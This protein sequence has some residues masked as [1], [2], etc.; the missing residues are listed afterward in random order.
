METRDE[1]L[2]ASIAAYNE[3]DCRATLA[4]RDWLVAHRPDD[5]PW[6]E[7]V[8][9]EA[10]DDADAGER[11]ELRAALVE[12]ADP[13]SARWL[14]GELL[15]YHRREARPGWWW[16]FERRDQMTDEELLDDAEAIG[17]LAP[18]GAPVADKRSFMHTL[19]FPPQQHKL[20]AGGPAGRP[21]DQ[22][23][24][25][26]DRRARRRRRDADAAPGAELKD[27]ALPRALVPAGPVPNDR[28]A[29]R[30]RAPRVVDARRRRPLRRAA[31]HPRAQAA[32]R[33]RPR[34]RRRG[35]DDRSRRAARA[36][37]GAGRELPLHPGPAGNRQDV[38]GRAPGHRAHAPA[39]GASASR[40]RATRRSTT[41]SPRWRRR[42]P[43]KAFASAASRR[44]P[45]A[46]TSRS[47]TAARSPAR[48]TSRRSPPPLPLDTFQRLVQPELAIEIDLLA[49]QM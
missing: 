46:T 49:G 27:V 1:A 36:R 33:S 38:D 28:A 40:R 22:E 6:A 30:A 21:G 14:A 34:T 10:R 32:A 44:R 18:V 13:G 16:F 37:G 48:P 19:A 45:T 8:A 26:H 12:G 15:E 3:E 24:G 43:R 4:L 39:A 11:D 41:C 5:A 17:G 47:T 42:R 9:A 29:R 20:G 35:P 31:R 2:L 23:V 7:A 25:R